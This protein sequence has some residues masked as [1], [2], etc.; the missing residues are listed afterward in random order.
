MVSL[1][2]G[3][4]LIVIS[5]G[6]ILWFLLYLG[7]AFLEWLFYSWIPCAALAIVIIFLIC[8]MIG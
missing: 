3:I 5:L 6:A 1:L 2:L 8:C 7:R 4:L